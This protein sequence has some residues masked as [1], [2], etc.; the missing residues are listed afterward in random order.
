MSIADWLQGRGLE[1]YKA[2]FARSTSDGELLPNLTADDPRDPGVTSVGH[3]RRLPEAIV[4]L[5]DNATPS[6]LDD[7]R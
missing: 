7:R 3:R 1:R 2:A 6:Q 4:V 5:K